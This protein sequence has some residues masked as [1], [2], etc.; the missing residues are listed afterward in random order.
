MASPTQWTWVWVNSRS[1]WW[2]GRPGVL[3]SMGLQS[4]TWLS[5][6]TE[7]N[8]TD[9]FPSSHVWMW[10]LDH[11]DCWAPKNWC[12]STLVLEKTLESPLD[13]K[14]I[15]P[16]NPKRNQQRVFIGRTETEAEAP[17]LLSPDA[18]SWLIG[19]D[20]DSGKDWRWEE[21][22]ATEDEMVGFITDSMDMSLSKLQEMVK[23]REA[24]HVTVLGVAK[25]RTW[26]TKQTTTD[27]SG[28]QAHRLWD[29][30][31]HSGGLLGRLSGSMMGE[32]WRL[33]TQAEGGAELWGGREKGLTP[34]EGALELG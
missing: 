4:R 16:V 32:E 15:K 12:F 21:K 27:V 18:K 8:W 9:G 2:T 11:E 6:W 25:S 3:Q 31:W 34:P 30:H 24:W 23:D 13:C 5:N 22:G 28:S 26:L 33:H 17:I 20:L 19:E 10:V 29:T 7:L 14:E 1:W